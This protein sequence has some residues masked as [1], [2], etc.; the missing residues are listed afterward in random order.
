MAR[1]IVITYEQVRKNQIKTIFL[2]AMYAKVLNAP[3]WNGIEVNINS[4][5][6]DLS[7]W[8]VKNLRRIL[9]IKTGI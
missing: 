4:E 2:I 7:K 6:F 9:D 3:Y 5:D 8:E 1:D